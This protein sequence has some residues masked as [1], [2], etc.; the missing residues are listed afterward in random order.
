MGGYEDFGYFQYDE[1]GDLA[2]TSLLP[3]IGDYP[4]DSEETWFI[5]QQGNDIYFQTFASIF[6]Y[7]P[8]AEQGKGCVTPIRFDL[9]HPLYLHQADGQLWAQLVED[10]YYRFTGQDY[11]L[12][13]PS[14]HYGNS[15][16]VATFQLTDD[17]DMLLCTEDAGLFLHRR[18]SGLTIPFH[19]TIDDQLRHAT[20]NR[21]VI[22]RDSTLVLGTIRDGIYG[23]DLRGKQRWH[24]NVA[25]GLNNNSVLNLFCDSDN[26]VWACLDSGIA[27]IHCGLPITYF[28]PS[29]AEQSIGTVYGILPNDGELLLA[30][31][32][33]FYHYN[34][35]GGK[36]AQL[37]AGTEGQNWH[38]SRFGQ[39]LFLGSNRSTYMVDEKRGYRLDA[40]PNTSASSTCIQQCRIWEQDVL[41][42]SSYNVL[43]VYRQQKGRWTFSNDIDG[44]SSPIRHFEVDNEGRIWAA[45]MQKGLFCITLDRELEAIEHIRTYERLDSLKEGTSTC[46]VMKLFGRIVLSDEQR[47]FTYDDMTQTI[48]PYDRLND[49]LFDTRDIYNATDAGRHGA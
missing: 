45:N 17:R 2:Y 20:I 34:I 22:T 21:A 1:Y 16:I 40:V 11:D 44:F 48:R 29:P 7:N 13:I 39:Q 31:N 6:R 37:V 49:L 12:V 15:R 24:Y 26:N 27:L 18:S 33:G 10:G 42:E 23:M 4:M 36:S 43:R 32:G 5:I 8:Q 35:D 41:I 19:T 28:K 3:L 25:D 47:L 46:H 30:T 38:I 14:S 9:K